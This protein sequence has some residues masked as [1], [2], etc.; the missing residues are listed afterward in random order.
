MERR[1]FVKSSLADLG[2]LLRVSS[3][4]TQSSTVGEDDSLLNKDNW[5]C[6]AF[7]PLWCSFDAIM[8]GVHDETNLL[9]RRD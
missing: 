1:T 5:D 7:R 2:A 3:S 4:K 9:I 8:F 6:L